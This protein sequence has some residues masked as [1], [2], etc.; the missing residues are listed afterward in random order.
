MLAYGA[1]E[2][3]C[4]G[5]DDFFV[6]AGGT[7]EC[8]ATTSGCKLNLLVWWERQHYNSTI[9]LVAFAQPSLEIVFGSEHNRDGLTRYGDVMGLQID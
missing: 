1:R 8:A 4:R 6:I 9:R 2:E 7:L 5:L 3:C